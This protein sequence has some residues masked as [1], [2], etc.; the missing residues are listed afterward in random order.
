MFWGW[1][2]IIDRRNVLLRLDIDRI[3]SLVF[4]TMRF[5][6]KPGFEGLMPE[7][8]Y[9]DKNTEGRE[10]KGWERVVVEVVVGSRETAM[11]VLFVQLD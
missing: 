5:F 1:L 3:F 11:A 10:G 7:R 2:S 6:N 8:D 9:K 4:L